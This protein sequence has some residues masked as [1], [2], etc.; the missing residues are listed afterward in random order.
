MNG[1]Y[2]PTDIVL[3]QPAG[4]QWFSCLEK[5]LNKVAAGVATAL[6]DTARTVSGKRAV[7]VVVSMRHNWHDLTAQ[8]TP[9]SSRS[10]CYALITNT[11]SKIRNVRAEEQRIQQYRFCLHDTSALCFSLPGATQMQKSFPHTQK[12][13]QVFCVCAISWMVFFL[14]KGL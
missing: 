13:P 11:G 12:K 14:F 10:C 8:C 5:E 7:V 3:L 4:S 1:T 9:L 6:T 2:K